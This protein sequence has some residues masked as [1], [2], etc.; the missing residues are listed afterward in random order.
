MKMTKSHE[1]DTFVVEHDGECGVG[2]I[3]I[4][5]RNA[6]YA[7]DDAG[8]VPRPDEMTQCA[9]TDLQSLT[10]RPEPQWGFSAGRPS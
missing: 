3:N 6:R 4:T 8:P 9:G 7:S 2:Q 10:P 5:S 1:A